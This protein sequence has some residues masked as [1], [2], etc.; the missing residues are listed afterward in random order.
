MSRQLVY[1][2][3]A[4]AALEINGINVCRAIA[5]WFFEFQT[6]ISTCCRLAQNSRIY[7]CVAVSAASAMIMVFALT[8]LGF[9][10]GYRRNF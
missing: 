9:T 8:V 10:V 4:L 5:A 1:A 6:Y 3:V 2:V 7:D